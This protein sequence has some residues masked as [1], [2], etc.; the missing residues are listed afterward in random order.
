M[1]DCRRAPSNAERAEEEMD[2]DLTSTILYVT[3]WL[4]GDIC[5]RE[6]RRGI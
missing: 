1:M 6:R 2:L 4:R 5:Q 3:I